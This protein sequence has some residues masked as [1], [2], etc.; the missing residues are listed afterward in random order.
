VI[1]TVSSTPKLDD[2][3][4]SPLLKAA[5][6]VKGDYDRAEIL[7]RVAKNHTLTAVTR[8]LYLAAADGIRSDYDQTRVLAELVRS[9]KTIK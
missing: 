2:G 6:S 5:A 1:D 8:P 3:V 4:L 9:E 7:V